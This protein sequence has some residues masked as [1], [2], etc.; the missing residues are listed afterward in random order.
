MSPRTKRNLNT[1]MQIEAFTHA[2]YLRFAARARMNENWDLARLF[3]AA[4]DADRIDH[5]AK[6]AD[7]AGLIANDSENLRDA[8]EDKRAE[9]A[10][11][12]QFAKEAT[13]DGDFTVADLFERVQ[14]T[15]VTQADAF[16]IACRTQ[17]RE[18]APGLVEA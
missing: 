2:K 17:V 7:V 4:A 8:V 14:T 10:M 11:Y 15:V 9:V 3:Q 12:K 1:A 16:E 13:A 6:E 5:F 18:C